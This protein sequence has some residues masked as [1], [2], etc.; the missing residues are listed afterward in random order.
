MARAACGYMSF[1][2]NNVQIITGIEEKRAWFIVKRDVH[3][4]NRKK[5][6]TDRLTSAE[7]RT[8]QIDAMPH[9]QL[10]SYQSEMK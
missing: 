6:V 4:H 3:N 8:W 7:E 1:T 5:F 2:W 10:M 9:L